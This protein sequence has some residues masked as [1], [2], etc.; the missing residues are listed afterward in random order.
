MHGR[1]LA[2]E[3]PGSGSFFNLTHYQQPLDGVLSRVH[4][5]EDDRRALRLGLVRE[6]LPERHLLRE[7]REHTVPFRGVF[8]EHGPTLEE[9]IPDLETHAR[10]ARH[11]AVPETRVGVLAAFE[12]HG[13][14]I[15]RSVV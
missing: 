15:E 11:V 2:V 8:D 10:V 4:P 5:Q 1:H 6:L 3:Q 12:I 14:D 13:W 9:A 7:R